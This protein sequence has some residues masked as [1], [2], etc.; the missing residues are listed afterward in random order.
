MKLK[1]KT[2][3]VS[4]LVFVAISICSI[5]MVFAGFHFFRWVVYIFLPLGVIFIMT[6]S[7]LAMAGKID[8][9]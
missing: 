8:K 1:Y 4:S 9:S 7:M 6:C 3:M 5:G 2:L